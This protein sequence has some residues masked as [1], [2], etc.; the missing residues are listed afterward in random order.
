VDSDARVRLVYIASIGRSGSTLLELMLGAHPRLATIGELHLWPHEIRD[1]GRHLP[2]GCG[3]PVEDCEFWTE[4]ARR[5]DPLGAPPPQIDYF[6]EQHTGGRTL[7]LDRLADFRAGAWN[8]TMPAEVAVYGANNERVYRA[9]LDLTAEATGTRPEAVVDSSKDPYRLRWLQASG[10]F[11]L[12]ILHVVRDPRGFVNSERK[13]VSAEGAALLALAARKAGAWVAVNR[14][15]ERTGRLAGLRAGPADRARGAGGYLLVPY[16]RLASDPRAT[17]VDVCTALGY[18]V[19]ETMLSRFREARF[20]AIG[21]NPM[22]HDDRGIR[23]DEAW[24]TELAPAGQRITQLVTAGSRG[25][26]G[27]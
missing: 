21:G 13:N 1:G 8:G 15:A 26:F 4:V 3:E 14:L 25:R 22:R 6:R 10:R 12:T 19:E 2:C 20:H 5:V 11:E 17:M 23:L 9:F 7:R 27:Y 18:D 24:R 16:E